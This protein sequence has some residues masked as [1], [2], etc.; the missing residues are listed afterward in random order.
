MRA[1]DTAW[2]TTDRRVSA[3]KRLNRFE[4]GDHL[5]ANDG[6]D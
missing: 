6:R 3:F 4:V 5:V 2:R 1:P